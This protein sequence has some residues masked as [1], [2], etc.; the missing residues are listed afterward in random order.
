ERLL[1]R[2]QAKLGEIFEKICRGDIVELG[3]RE[4]A[5][6]IVMKAGCPML[7]EIFV[8]QIGDAALLGFARQPVEIVGRQARRSRGGEVSQGGNRVYDPRVAGALARP[9]E[10]QEKSLDRQ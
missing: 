5:D 1:L 10:G 8:R 6:D 9:R 4:V 2:L 3:R 7:V